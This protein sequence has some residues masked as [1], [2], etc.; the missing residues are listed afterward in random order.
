D[1]IT[2]MLDAHAVLNNIPVFEPRKYVIPDASLTKADRDF[3][4][5]QFS[6]IIELGASGA[7]L[8]HKYYAE[9]RC[10]YIQVENKGFYHLINDPA[11]LGV[12]QFNPAVSLRLRAKTHSSEPIHNYS[13][14]AVL[15]GNM[16]S[17]TPS[18]YDICD[19]SKTCPI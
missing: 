4:R 9:K 5:R 18:P 19:A 16:K 17:I 6:K 11:G 13:F 12:P 2:H 3:D 10:F 14:R 15:T 7:Y 1:S 8:I